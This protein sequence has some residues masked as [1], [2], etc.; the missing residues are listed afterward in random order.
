MLVHR[1]KVPPREAE[2][3]VRAPSGLCGGSLGFEVIV[4]VAAP[5]IV[6]CS[7]ARTPSIK[8]L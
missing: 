5:P 4:A 8:W 3:E 2:W 7:E 6:T 1:S